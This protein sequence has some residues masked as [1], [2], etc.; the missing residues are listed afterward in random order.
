MRFIRRGLLTVTLW[1]ILLSVAAQTATPDRNY[2]FRQVNDQILNRN[3]YFLVLLD[4]LPGIN[5]ILEKDTIMLRLG[6]VYR[7]RFA[8]PG[9]SRSAHQLVAPFLIDSEH[10]AAAAGNWKSLQQQYP[11]ALKELTTEMRRSG[12]FQRYAGDEDTQLLSHAWQ[13]AL[14]GINYILNA[15]TTNKGL[16]YPKIDSAIYAVNG[17]EYARAVEGLVAKRRAGK[18]KGLFYQ[19]TLRLASDLLRLNNHDECARYEPMSGTNHNAYTQVSRTDWDKFRYSA[20][21]I[22]GAGPGNKEPISDFGKNR[23][24]IG[25]EYFRKG[26]AA[27]IIV[28]GGHVHPIG[29]PYAEATEMKKYLVNE[30]KI[31]AD[32][33][34]IE[35]YARHTTTNVR[36][37]V[38]LA[39]YSGMPTDKPMLCVSDA[40]QLSYISSP[41]FI[42]RCMTEL[43]YMPAK[44]ITQEDLYFLS[45]KPQLI[46]LHADARDPLDP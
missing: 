2:V 35:P 46:S 10:I 44:A 18:E 24:R 41:V 21:L 15:Y 3:F 23:C 32:A 25:A 39:W 28:S 9:N 38:R 13:D 27:F 20:I 7:S 26:G 33:V 42:Q 36:N 14:E 1:G 5:R 31:P 17:P 8:A 12:L 40:L 4:K 11:A 45:F 43:G 22:P 19:R 6:N 34:I 29:T 30:L 37:A 16:R